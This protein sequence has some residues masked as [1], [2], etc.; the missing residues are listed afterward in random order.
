MPLQK[1][2]FVEIEFTGRT[3]DG[4]IFDS[5]RPEDLREA[6]MKGNPS[7]FIFALGQEMF[8]K[9]VEEF[10][11]GKEVG[12]YK[13]ELEPENA[14]GKRNPSLIQTIPIKQFLKQNINPLPGTV[15]NF[16]GKLGK[17]LTVSG[18]RVMVD[19]NNLLAGKNV[20]YDINVLR[21]VEK[22]DEKVKALNDFLFNKDFEFKI[23]GKKLT[24][25]TDDTFKG[26]VEL[27]KDKYKEILDLDLK[28]EKIEPKKEE[29]STKE[30]SKEKVDRTN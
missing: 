23:E 26:I 8:L 15:L 24:I 20:S 29:K 4:K 2:D 27:F 18:G 25:M 5:N 17:I 28:T 7:P 30:E 21:K 22:L 12:K 13:I 11:I 10:L 1:K 3:E 6:N 14:F 9:G 19:F 16:D